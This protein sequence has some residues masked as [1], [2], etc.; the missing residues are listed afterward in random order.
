MKLHLP[1]GCTLVKAP[2]PLK[3]SVRLIALCGMFASATFVTAMAGPGGGPGGS[4]DNSAN[5][6]DFKHQPEL[7]WRTKPL[8][9]IGN[10]QFKDLNGNGKL[11]AYED[12]RL[13]VDERVDDLVS[14]MTLEEK[15]GMMLI[16]TLNAGCKG[17][18]SRTA[19]DYIRNQKM[20]RFILRSTAAATADEATSLRGAAAT[21]DAGA[22]G[23]VRERGPG[24]AEAT[25]LGI[26][27]VFKYNARNHY[28][29]RPA[30][31]HHDGAGAF[32][33][34]PKEAGLAAA[35]LGGIRKARTGDMSVIRLHRRDGP[36]VAA[37]GLRGMYGYMADLSTEPRWY[38]VHET[39]TEDADLCADIMKTLVRDAAGRPQVTPATNVAL[40]IKH[41]P[42]GGPQELGLDPHYLVRQAP[43]LSG[44]P[45]RLPPEAVQGG[46]RR[47]R[48]RR[49]CRTTACRSARRY[50]GRDL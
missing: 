39:F 6:E 33:E 26:P 43:G 7:G 36:G 3:S 28:R 18:W 29:N 44:R 40:T 37:I 16:D 22:T 30:L 9:R 5:S 50:D 17:A 47:R 45:V 21:G 41:F 46:D 34:F 4:N 15:T 19:T 1:D 11:D 25:R 12:W 14:Q 42:G 2:F 31:R 35:A 38:R 10:K 24:R 20:T 8:I 49:S 32:T 13:P 48:R 27:V 23:R